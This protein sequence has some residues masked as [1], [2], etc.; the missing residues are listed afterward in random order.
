MYNGSVI[1]CL[2]RDSGVAGL[3]VTDVTALCLNIFLLLKVHCVPGKTKYSGQCVLCDVGT[4][5]EDAGNTACTN[6]SSIRTTVSEGSISQ[7]D[8]NIGES[9]IMK[10]LKSCFLN[11]LNEKMSRFSGL[12]SHT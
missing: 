11:I 4:Y 12:V 7:A 2:T 6:C 10:C 5:K 1:E 9:Y 3:S 8:C